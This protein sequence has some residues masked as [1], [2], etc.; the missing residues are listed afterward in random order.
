MDCSLSMDDHEVGVCSGSGEVSVVF[1]EFLAVFLG[2]QAMAPTQQIR[3]MVKHRAVW[4]IVMFARFT[5]LFGRMAA[6]E[7][8][9]Q[10]WEKLSHGPW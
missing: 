4:F 1:F 9:L 7:C 5:Q 2:L 6:V 3:A 10:S 8:V